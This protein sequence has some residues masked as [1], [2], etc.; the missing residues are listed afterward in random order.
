MVLGFAVLEPAP[1]GQTD[2]DALEHVG[3]VLGVG[4]CDDA[5]LVC[6]GE[7]VGFELGGQVGFDREYF[8]GGL[9]HWLRL[10]YIDIL[11]TLP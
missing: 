10:I 7:G 4:P 2:A 5:V 8:E 3:K 11:T 6:Q 1:G 9:G